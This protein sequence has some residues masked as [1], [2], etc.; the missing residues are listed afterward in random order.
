MLRVIPRHLKGCGEVSESNP[1]PSKQRRKCPLWAKGR[2]NGKLIRCSLGTAN[3]QLAAQRVAEIEAT[4]SVLPKKAPI[5]VAEAAARFLKEA[6]SRELRAST[7]KKMRVVL[8]REPRLGERPGQ[9]SPI[10]VMFARARR[11]EFLQDFTPDDGLTGSLSW[12]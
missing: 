1:C 9:I 2:L 3:W 5:A 11:I 6:E 8:T 12:G 10:L 4:G 7:L